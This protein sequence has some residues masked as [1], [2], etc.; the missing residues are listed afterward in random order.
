ML[1]QDE[2]LQKLSAIKQD[3]TLLGF[4]KIG[5]F[6]SISQ[7]RHSPISDIDIAV[8]S[9]RDITD[10]GFEYLDKLDT[11]KY[12]LYKLFKRPVD[13]YDLNRRKKTD[14]SSEIEKEVIY[15]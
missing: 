10:R 1:A 7:N 14:I 8:I 9:N 4:E 11:L 2:V 3:V 12:L 15:A 13:I 6:G 5:V